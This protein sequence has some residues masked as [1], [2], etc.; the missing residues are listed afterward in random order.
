M[1]SSS[2]RKPPVH[3]PPPVHRDEIYQRVRAG[4]SPNAFFPYALRHQQTPD[5]YEAA[6]AGLKVRIAQR[7]GVLTRDESTAF[8]Y[9]HRC[10]A[11][12][13]KKLR[14][15]G[16]HHGHCYPVLM[17]DGSIE[18]WLRDK[19]NAHSSDAAWLNTFDRTFRPLGYILRWDEGAGRLAATR[20]P[21]YFYQRD[22]RRALQKDDGEDTASI[23][24]A[25]GEEP[26]LEPLE[27]PLFTPLSASSSSHDW[28]MMDD[29][30]VPRR[31]RASPIVWSPSDIYMD[32]YRSGSR[33]VPSSEVMAVSP[34]P[35]GAWDQNVNDYGLWR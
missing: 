17:P 25:D 13:W 14:Q 33:A 30:A 12:L 11:N 7:D 31:A 6:I 32:D 22:L 35:N 18:Y 2:R 24:S 20:S 8:E 27:P 19:A 9:L 29:D 5:R 10:E 3:F 15:T 28:T 1:K 16:L 4:E 23:G 21:G 34:H 26:V